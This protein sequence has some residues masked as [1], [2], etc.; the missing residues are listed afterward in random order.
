[1]AGIAINCSSQDHYLQ[2]ATLGKKLASQA[3]VPVIAISINQ[4]VDGFE[5]AGVDKVISVKGADPIVENY[6]KEIAA[7]LA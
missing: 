1:M 7:V 2:I 6:A 3:G 5:W 4:D